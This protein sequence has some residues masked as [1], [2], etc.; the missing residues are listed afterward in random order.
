MAQTVFFVYKEDQDQQIEEVN[1]YLELAEK[2]I[3]FEEDNVIK[4]IAFI[5]YS[6]GNYQKG[7]KLLQRTTPKSNQGDFYY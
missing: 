7:V 5:Y 1:Q 3:N 6:I 2:F 4:E